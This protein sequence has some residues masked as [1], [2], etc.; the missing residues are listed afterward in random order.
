[1]DEHE[2]KV[3]QIKGGVLVLSD[4]PK[5]AGVGRTEDDARQDLKRGLNLRAAILE[6]GRRGRESRQ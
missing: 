2:W 3:I 5:M 6:R 4:E 1:M